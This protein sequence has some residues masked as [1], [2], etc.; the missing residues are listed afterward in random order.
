MLKFVCEN[1]MTF[2][3]RLEYIFEDKEFVIFLADFSFTALGD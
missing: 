3:V 2:I 1:V